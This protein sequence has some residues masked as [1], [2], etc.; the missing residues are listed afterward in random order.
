MGMMGQVRGL[1]GLVTAV[2][3]AVGAM[4]IA[5]R[6]ASARGRELQA[7]LSVDPFV[8]VVGSD[9]V[10]GTQPYRFMG[11]NFWYG[12]NLGM[13]GPRGDRARLGR[14]LD[15]LAA[16]GVTNLRI[17]AASEGPDTEPYR[18]LPSLQVAPG[19]Y[20]ED[21]FV[22]LDY[23]LVAMA[24]RGIR[25]V[26][27]LSNFWHWSGGFAQYVS[28][29]EGG[30]TIPYPPQRADYDVF[31][32]YV[33]KFYVNA[34]ARAYYDDF[35]KVILAR[36]NTISGVPYRSD[37]T[38]MAWEIANEPRA[39][40]HIEP[41]V[42]WVTKTSRTLRSLAPRQ[43]ITTGSEGYTP[44]FEVHTEVERIHALPTIDYLTYH[45]WVQNWGRFDPRHPEGL[46]RAITFA[47]QYSADH[48]SLAARLGKPA[49]LEEF[50]LARDDASF[51]SSAP[52]TIRDRYY[53]AMFG[54]FIDA[55]RRGAPAAGV[56]FWAFGGEGRP[57][58]P[59]GDW[60]LGEP[61]IGDPPHEPQGWYSVY[62]QDE[63]TIGVIRRFA[64]ELLALRR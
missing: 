37:P 22:G 63:A 61:F 29:A 45:I 47:Q 60:H 2:V 12:M 58:E 28:W 7:G 52:T 14:E 41:F 6:E 4:S 1:P 55:A 15:R 20:N 43:L 30:S 23:L 13:P 51:S 42:D 11:A 59:G 48:I 62:D 44:Y 27:C 64:D 18:M 10:L 3:M 36:V 35:L 50:G 46:S 16:M 24:E 54:H 5:S 9:F 19:Q 33:A 40:S 49:V 31:Q 56:A 53:S 17:M 39:M 26:L 38:I 8:K 21:V 34:K 32:D 25:G 57:K